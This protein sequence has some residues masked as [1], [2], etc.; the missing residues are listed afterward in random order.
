[1]RLSK[2]AN[3]S[4]TETDAMDLLEERE[5]ISLLI[6]DLKKEAEE[7]KNY[8]EVESADNKTNK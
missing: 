3:I 1:M 6:K 2:I 8:A 7:Y 5:L 4:I